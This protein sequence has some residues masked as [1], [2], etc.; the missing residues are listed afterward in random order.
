MA[1]TVGLCPSRARGKLVRGIAG[2]LPY[3]ELL[4]N[5]LCVG[6][7]LRGSLDVGVGDMTALNV[8]GIAV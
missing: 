2:L 5:A 7:D 3:M 1:I 4:E 8:V 6:L